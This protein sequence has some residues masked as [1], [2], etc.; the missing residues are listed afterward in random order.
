MIY[1]SLLQLKESQ[2]E[3]EVLLHNGCS[4]KGKIVSISIDAVIVSTYLEYGDEPPSWHEAIIK[5]SQIS[6]IIYEKELGDF[7]SSTSDTKKKKLK[8]KHG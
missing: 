7:P 3:V 4:F 5:L 8:K 1:P 2:K 6:S